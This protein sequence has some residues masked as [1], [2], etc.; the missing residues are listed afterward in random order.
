MEKITFELKATTE[1][2]KTVNG[3]LI[4]MLNSYKAHFQTAQCA[5]HLWK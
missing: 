1:P 4:I 2:E 3:A 5:M